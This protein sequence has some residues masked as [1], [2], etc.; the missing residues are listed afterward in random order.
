MAKRTVKP[1]GTPAETSGAG[2]EK[3]DGTSSTLADIAT[4]TLQD[5]NPKIAG[6]VKGA[7]SR[8]N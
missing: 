7:L 2:P 6:L 3:D 4:W 8:K 1:Q 5:N